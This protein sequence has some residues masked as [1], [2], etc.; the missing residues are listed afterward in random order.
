MD[1][2]RILAAA[3]ALP[4]TVRAEIAEHLLTSL[5]PEDQRSEEAWTTEIQQRIARWE[6]GEEQAIPAEEVFNKLYQKYGS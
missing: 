2:Q 6:S 1:K 3:L 5:E 4:E